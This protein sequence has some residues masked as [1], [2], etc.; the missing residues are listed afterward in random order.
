MRPPSHLVNLK[1][2]SFDPS[3]YPPPY[4]SQTSIFF[5]LLKEQGIICVTR[6]FLLLV[7]E[8]LFYPITEGT[9]A[10]L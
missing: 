2:N 9:R 3:I 10:N 5:K 7:V 6:K 8:D 4:I 1:E